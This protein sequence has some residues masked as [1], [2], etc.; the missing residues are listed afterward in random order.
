MPPAGNANLD[1]DKLSKQLKKVNPK[2]AS[3]PGSGTCK[4]LSILQDDVKTGLEITVDRSIQENK[5][6]NAWKLPKVKTA[7][8]KEK[9]K[10]SQTIDPFSC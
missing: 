7:Q 1:T 8:K 4:E 3:G 9:D 5:Y 2:K 6:P 10:K